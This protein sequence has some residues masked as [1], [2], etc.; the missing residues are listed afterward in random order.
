MKQQILQALKDVLTH[1]KHNNQETLN[2]K[3]YLIMN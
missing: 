2:V 1:L 3:I